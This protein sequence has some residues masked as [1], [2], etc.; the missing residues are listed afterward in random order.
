MERQCL[1][2]LSGGQD[3]TTCL[4]WAK[5]HWREVHAITFDY[6]Q[7]HKAEVDAAKRVA[8]MADVSSHRIVQCEGILRSA[9][10]LLSDNE[11]EQ[12]ES[13]EQ[14]DKVIGNRVEKTFVPLRNPFFLLVAA[15]HALHLGSK[16][17]V[18]GVCQSDNANYPDCR[19]EFLNACEAMMQEALGS[20]VYIY[21]PLLHLNKQKICEM[22][23]D[24]GSQCWEALS[25]TLTSYDGNY[26]PTDKNHSNVLRAQG[27]LDAMLPDPLVLRAVREGLMTLPG[28]ANYDPFRRNI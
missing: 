26:P 14:M 24:L 9:S 21:T 3:S 17:I 23:H 11:L 4:F 28:T 10:P 18:T 13:Y 22:A 20:K 27:F 8:A 25:Y 6:G 16:S 1:V 15:N 19:G 5:K 12:Y 2:I 7:R